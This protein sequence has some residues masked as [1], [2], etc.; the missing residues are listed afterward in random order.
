MSGT[1]NGGKKAKI[2]NMQKYG[3]DFYARIG[4]KGGRAPHD[5]P[6]WFALHPELA[7]QC[8]KKGGT[9]SRRGPAKKNNGGEDGE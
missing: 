1:R 2:T 3:E 9:I 8:G 6:R 4:G 7:K 5:A